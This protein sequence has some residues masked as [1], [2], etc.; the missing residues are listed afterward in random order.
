MFSKQQIWL[1]PDIDECVVD[2]G[3]CNQI[4]VNKPGSFECKCEPGYLLS[5]DGKTCVGKK[6]CLIFL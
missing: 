1:L 4:C 3:G 2:N 6:S 5:D